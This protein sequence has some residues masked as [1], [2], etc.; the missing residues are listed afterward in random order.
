[1]SRRLRRRSLAWSR[2]AA[3]RRWSSRGGRGSRR[4]C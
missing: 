2:I 3:I 4:L 1:V